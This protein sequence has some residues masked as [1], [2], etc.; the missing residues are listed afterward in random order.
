M[1][2]DGVV[3]ILS[4]VVILAALVLLDDIVVDVFVVEVVDSESLVATS[5][6]ESIHSWKI[7]HCSIFFNN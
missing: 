4:E 7:C 5:L 3:V 2:V 1:E 6:I